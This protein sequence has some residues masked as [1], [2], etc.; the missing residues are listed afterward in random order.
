MCT[1]LIA[2]EDDTKRPSSEGSGILEVVQ[3][4]R[5]ATSGVRE[6]IQ[7][8]STHARILCWNCRHLTPVTEDRC[9]ACGA[10]ITRPAPP[11]RTPPELSRSEDDRELEEARRSLL[12][13][14]EDLQRVYDV[15]A[16]RTEEPALEDSPL[17]FQCPACGRF[18]A[19]DAASCACGVHFAPDGARVE[20]ACPRCGAPVAADAETCR[21]GVRFSD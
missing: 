13:L 12:Q 6:A 21:C 4:G 18:V 14:F 1:E 16:H 11:P 2:S 7:G 8:D 3:M 10:K 5:K 19:E 20:Y 15:S 17:L 9:S